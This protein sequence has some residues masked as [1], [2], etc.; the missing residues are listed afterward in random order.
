MPWS[1]PPGPL[2][3]NLLDTGN[4]TIPAEIALNY[5]PEAFGLRQSELIGAGLVLFVLTFLVNMFARWIVGRYSQ[6]SGAN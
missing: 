5:P 2:T 1:S 3:A 4:N 6:F